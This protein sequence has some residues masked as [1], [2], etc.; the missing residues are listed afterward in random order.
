[1]LKRRKFIATALGTAAT[2]LLPIT[3][4]NTSYIPKN[5]NLLKGKQLKKGDTIGLV[6]P[7]YAVSSEGLEHA[8]TT[9]RKM[10]FIPYHTERIVG[11]YGYFSN[12]DAER[13]ADLNEMFANPNIDGILC[14]RGGYGCT[15]IMQLIDYKIIKN[16]PKV[17]IGFS[18]ITTLLNGFYIETGLV[19]FHGPVGTTLDNEYG[20]SMLEQLVINP[21]KSVVIHNSD[22]TEEQKENTEYNRYVITPG[23]AKGVLV[24]GSL[25]LINALIGT[26]HEIDFTNKIVCIEDVEES[27]YRIDRML[28]QLIEGKTFKNAA[29]LVL[30]VFA[31]CETS[32]KTK[33]FTLKEVITDRLQPLNI[34]AVY[35]MS[36]GHIPA[37]FTFPIGVNAKLSTASMTLTITEKA[38]L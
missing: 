2:S 6:A 32:K 18:D 20:I 11:N 29:G 13:A 17:F 23:N 7:G 19:G 5:N 38:V 4:S 35:G 12:T 1:M 16:N 9:L 36:F 15:R 25:T 8:K 28:T 24:G 37:N 10:G 31:G 3:I 27:P 21:K 33:T 26:P 22:L 30:G 34:P 14:A